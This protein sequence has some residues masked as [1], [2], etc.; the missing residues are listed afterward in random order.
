M[1]SLSFFT[2]AFFYVPKPALS[3]IIMAAVLRVVEWQQVRELWFSD[4][5]DLLV[6]L[7]ENEYRGRTNLQ[8]V[9]EDARPS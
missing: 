9:V 6:R 4:R 7:E 3:A 1:L 8:L 5:F 2:P